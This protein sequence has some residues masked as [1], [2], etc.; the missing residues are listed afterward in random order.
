V[1]GAVG[2]VVPVDVEVAGCPPTPDQIVAALRAITG[3]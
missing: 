2:D 1:A 3:R